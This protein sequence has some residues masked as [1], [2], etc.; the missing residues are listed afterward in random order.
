MTISPTA[1]SPTAQGVWARARLWLL[2]GVAIVAT[3]VLVVLGSA[4]SE[5]GSLDPRSYRPDGSRAL[6]QL[7]E[8]QG[9]RVEHTDDAS[10][11][12]GATLFVTHPDLLAPERLMDL[13][14]RAATTVLVAPDGPD[15]RVEVETREPGCELAAKAGSATTGGIQYKGA[16]SCYDSTLVRDGN[17]VTIGTGAPFTNDEL[18]AEGNAALAM[19]LL[20]QHERLVWYTP[21]VADLSRQRTMSDL[22]P[23]GWKFGA[24]QLALAAVVISLWRARR[25]GPVVT[26]PLPVVVRAAET[27]E[28]RARLY[29]RS[30]AS[31]H[32]AS[33]LRQ[34][35]RDRLNPLLGLPVGEDPA[36]EIAR[37]T[38]RPETEV[39]ALLHG[40]GPV[41]DRGLVDLIDELDV[42]ENEVRRG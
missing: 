28:G 14:G 26:E 3:A 10:D 37:R 41:D 24:L 23:D 22:M 32:A 27:V 34:A 40:E 9:V 13:S 35:T 20:G 38:G 1:I 4:R 19:K 17:M 12:D 7:L 30:L 29:R 18:D 11:V 16:E 2:L 25:L 21:S 39:R 15:G 8:Q 36:Q 5:G 33:V 6:A 42:L 31:D